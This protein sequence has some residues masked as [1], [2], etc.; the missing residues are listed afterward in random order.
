MCDI[1]INLSVSLNY[2]P[3]I[4]ETSSFRYDKVQTYF[5]KVCA[6]VHKRPY[7]IKLINH[8]KYVSFFDYALQH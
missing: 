5:E 4:L 6:H 2:G 3:M 1:I 8:L 7:A